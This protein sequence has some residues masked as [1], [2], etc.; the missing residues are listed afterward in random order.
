MPE[1]LLLFICEQPDKN[2]LE[3][4]AWIRKDPQQALQEFEA[5]ITRQGIQGADEV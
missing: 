2:L 4:L 5:V 1:S 3:L